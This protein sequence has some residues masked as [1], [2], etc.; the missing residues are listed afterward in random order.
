MQSRLPETEIDNL[1]LTF[2]DAVELALSGEVTE[3]YLC[4]VFGARRAAMFR[5]SGEPWAEELIGRYIRAR[6]C[7][8][9][10]FGLSGEAS[11]VVDIKEKSTNRVLHSVSAGTLVEANLRGIPLP[12]A[13]L[14]RADLAGADLGGADL[15]GA[16]LK[17]ANLRGANL[18]RASLRGAELEDA[19]LQ[20]A[21]LEGA[22]LSEAN[23][24]HADL[25]AA[26][27]G[28]TRLAG[29]RLWNAFYDAKTRWPSGFNP[30]RHGL[31]RVE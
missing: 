10:R 3:G 18:K 14:Y 7:Y 4:L 29:A 17:A 16:G 12:G 23:L 31:R 2:A 9:K 25:R 13:D 24:S 26:N 15:A 28:E 30:H 5:L 8:S 22:D 6:E 11:T 20:W 21:C 19:D 1:L 27:L